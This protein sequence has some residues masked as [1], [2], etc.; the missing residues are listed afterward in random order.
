MTS[1]EN[2]P[3]R[4]HPARRKS[5]FSDALNKISNTTFNRRR[6]PS[7][8]PRSTSNNV[9]PRSHL[10][11]P[12]GIPRSTTFL[13]SLSDFNHQNVSRDVSHDAP[14]TGSRNRPAGEHK[15]DQRRRSLASQGMANYSDAMPSKLTKRRDSSVMIEQR[16]L[17]QPMLP[18]LPKS[19]TMAVLPTIHSS[20]RAANLS[21]PKRKSNVLE[22]VSTQALA[23]AADG[24]GLQQPGPANFPVRK[25]S[26]GPFHARTTANL[27]QRDDGPSVSHSTPPTTNQRATESWNSDLSL[28]LPLHGAQRKMGSMQ[29][30]FAED[31]TDPKSDFFYDEKVHELDFALQSGEKCSQTSDGARDE[32]GVDDPCLV[33]HFSASTSSNL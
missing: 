5:S 22:T 23:P 3:P 15:Q 11:T 28:P 8:L 27:Q 1:D 24:I 33:K 30:S 21:K 26:L 4:P 18:P 17:M 25:D 31:F 19:N 7:L 16:G 32:A 6:T 2:R 13:T 14:V 9:F 20:P 29:S 10:P 12:S